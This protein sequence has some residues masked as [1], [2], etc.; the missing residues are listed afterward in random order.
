MALDSRYKPTKVLGEGGFGK[1]YLAEDLRQFNEPCVIKQLRYQGHGTAANA[2]IK[3]LFVKEAKLLQSL[4][5]HSQI[6]ALLAYI[7]V[8]EQLYWVQQF[9]NGQNLAQELRQGGRYGESRLRQFLLEMLLIL[10]FVHQQGVIHR[11]L[12]PANI[13]RRSANNE[14][15]LIDFGLSRQLSSQL[16]TVYGTVVGTPGYAAPEQMEPDGKVTPASDLYSLGA[17]CFELL[18]QMHPSKM[19]GENWKTHVN[20]PLSPTMS[21]V[22]GKL[23]KLEANRRYQS[24]TEVLRD[25][26]PQVSKTRRQVLDWGTKIATGLVTGAILKL[27]WDFLIP[28]VT[29][30]SPP[31]AFQARPSTPTPK[32]AQNF[33]EALGNGVNLEMVSIPGGRFLMGSP[34]SEKDRDDD[35]GP[36]HEVNVPPFYMGQYEVTQAQ[37]G[38]IMGQ[39]PS[40]F[41][42]AD[43]PVESVTW[44]DAQAFCQKLSAKTGKNYR[45]PSEAEWEYACRA[46]T[47]TAYSFGN[48]AAVLGEYAW[49]YGNSKN[50]PHPV[51][52]K[53]PNA[54]GLYDMHGNVWEWCEDIYRDSYKGAPTDGSAWVGQNA[55][56][57][58]CRGGSWINSPGLCRSA[59]RDRNARGN[60]L[61]NL[62]FRVA[63]LSG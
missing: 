57:R 27:I 55:G 47:T 29:R 4:G 16:Y 3:E 61:Y 26:Q 52:Q 28:Q 45:L 11:D 31:K 58:V 49:F 12:K 13:M 40:R 22:M 8:G 50:Q 53:K 10:E 54:F 25:L 42:G 5:H 48:D 39:N 7:A 43:R 15:V 41:K 17:T 62:G 60:R 35:E 46:G 33:S 6:P 37:Y 56:D 2:K 32:P 59:L 23:L 9:V 36:Q 34:A 44:D 19:R 24:A 38:A 63:D 51:G 21:R 30:T 20:P 14:L 18:T 1:T